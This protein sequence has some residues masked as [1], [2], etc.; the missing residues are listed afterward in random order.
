MESL[1]YNQYVFNRVSERKQHRSSLWFNNW[2][3]SVSWYQPEVAVLRDNLSFERVQYLLAQRKHFEKSRW[4]H[5]GVMVGAMKPSFRSSITPETEHNVHSVRKWLIDNDNT[6][7]TVFY[8]GQIVIYANDRAVID[9]AVELAKTFVIGTI[10][11]QEAL[12]T[13]PANT[14]VLITPYDYHYRTYL[15]SRKLPDNVILSLRELLKGMGEEVKVSP[16]FQKFLDGS[17]TRKSWKGPNLTWDHYFFDH[18]DPKLDTWLSMLSP[19]IIRKTM[20]IQS[21]AK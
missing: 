5:N 17:K 18:N 15:K 2:Q 12:V 10:L 3:W 19:G 4:D 6:H 20:H 7:K 21:P 8:T 9:S 16:S 13:V 14:K 1:E 11:V